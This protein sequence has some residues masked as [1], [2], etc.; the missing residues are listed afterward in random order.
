MK[1][2]IP[3]FAL[4]VSTALTVQSPPVTSVV[5]TASRTGA[6]CPALVTFD[7]RITTSSAV[8]VA[9]RWIGSDGG[10]TQPQNAS[11]SGPGTHVLT[12][13]WTLSRS[14]K[15][16]LQLS[17]EQPVAVKSQP[18]PFEVACTAEGVLQPTAPVAPAAQPAVTAP[19]P[20]VDRGIE[21]IIDP[22]IVSDPNMTRDVNRVDPDTAFRNW[23][24]ER[25][26][27]G[28]IPEGDAF[29]RQP[30]YSDNVVA[31]RVRHDLALANGGIGGDY[32]RDLPYPIGHRGNY[33]IGTYEDHPERYTQRENGVFVD[34]SIGRTQGDGPTGTLTS[35]P[36]VV[37][38]AWC[39]FLIGGGSDRNLL[40]VE[41]QIRQNDGTWR[42]VLSRTSF[43]NSEVMYRTEFALGEFRGQIARIH[44][45]DNATG[46]WGHINVDDFR[47]L[48]ALPPGIR[49]QSAGI[50]YRIDADASVWGAADTHEHPYLD[51]AHGGNV[52]KGRLSGAP[53][54]DSLPDDGWPN[55]QYRPAFDRGDY[56]KTY[57]AWLHRA[58]QGGVRLMSGLAVNNWMFASALMKR[59]FKGGEGTGSWSFTIS[60]GSWD[61]KSIATAQIAAIKAWARQPDVASWLGIATTP[62]EARELIHKNK[63][64]LVLGIEVDLLGNFVEREMGDVRAR[65]LPAD[66]NERRRLIAAELDALAASGVRQVTPIHYVSEPW[67]GAAIFNRWFNEQN[68]LFTGRNVVVE[69]GDRWGIRYRVTNDQWGTGDATARELITGH[70]RA[71][72]SDPSWET[73]GR[74]HVNS[75]GLSATGQI[76]LEELAKR[77][78]LI[79]LEHASYKTTSGMFDFARSRLM[80]YPLMSSHTDMGQLSF[81]GNGE[82]R[83]DSV[84]NLDE[85]NMAVFGTT[86]HQNLRHEGQATDEKLAGIRSLGGTLGI[87]ML[88]YRKYAYRDGAYVRN[89]NDGSTKTWAQMYLYG[90]NAMEGRNVGFSMDQGFVKSLSPRF[91]LNSA[92]PLGTE[93]SDA[94]K[95]T[96][97]L[98]QTL[99]QRNGVTYDSPVRYK[100]PSWIVHEFEHTTDWPRFRKPDEAH[101]FAFDGTG[102]EDIH[103]DGWI[104]LN[105]FKAGLNPWRV[106]DDAL[107]VSGYPSHAGRIRN[108]ARGFFLGRDQL[109]RLRDDCGVLGGDCRGA[110]I[111]ERVAAF[112]VANGLTPNELPEFRTDAWVQENY[113]VLKT[114]WDHWENM[115]GAGSGNQHWPLRRYTFGNAEWDYNMD[116]LAHYGLIPDFFQDLY[117]VLRE[118]AADGGRKPAALFAPLFRSAEDY[119]R[120]WERADSLKSAIK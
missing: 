48:D 47:F 27:E 50:V 74:G 58:Y 80:G 67:G 2:T 32:W 8:T 34:R 28:W 99:A 95:K 19:K 5:L 92:Y 94:L 55:F 9:Y 112:C 70:S 53:G 41:L 18:A 107:P 49:M 43:R 81:T 59:L 71:I 36:F 83:H 100:K 61:D 119:L 4:L 38:K 65:V 103:V 105:A 21:P 12:T 20:R 6:Q 113:Q 120:M 3:L 115:E 108:F 88:P 39:D 90:I 84:S 75:A 117:N 57:Q 33:W 89:D 77:G 79:D 30:T 73:V 10:M 110:A 97:R 118:G 45:I 52:V 51:N 98:E 44:I 86:L 64:A 37:T 76:L 69:S 62:A 14:F 26:L 102:K 101:N 93:F 54:P 31:G 72:A 25:Q 24:F 35:P 114:L 104:A 66:P 40:R 60:G 7:A 78:L 13:T 17:I 46:D 63:M 16:W 56:T 116:G 109:P 85:P 15:G 96:R 87:I 111:H 23:D 82:W 42:P 68:R 106:G 29:A 22:R 91:G 11:F 1:I